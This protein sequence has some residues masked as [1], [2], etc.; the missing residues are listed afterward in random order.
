MG[1]VPKTILV[2]RDAILTRVLITDEEYAAL[3]RL[4]REVHEM[5]TAEYLGSILRLH[6]ESYDDSDEEVTSNAA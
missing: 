6:L 2:E 1:R 3:K 5:P 4:A